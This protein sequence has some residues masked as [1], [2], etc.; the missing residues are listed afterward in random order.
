[1]TDVEVPD[2]QIT[3]RVDFNLGEV[4]SEIKAWMILRRGLL[5][6]PTKKRPTRAITIEGD[7][8]TNSNER[9]FI[10]IQKR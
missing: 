10:K 6:K 1:M 5:K 2:I 8:I 9:E 3:N 4:T 7:R